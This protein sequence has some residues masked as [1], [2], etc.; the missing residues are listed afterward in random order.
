MLKNSQT[1]F[2]NLVVFKSQY[3]RRPLLSIMHETIKALKYV[4][5]K[6]WLWN[7]KIDFFPQILDS[8]IHLKVASYGNKV[9]N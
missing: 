1:Y 9:S 7:H 8:C 2:K 4:K 3:F 5:K 6:E